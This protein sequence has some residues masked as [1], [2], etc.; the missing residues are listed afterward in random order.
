MNHSIFHL[1]LL[2][3]HTP[4]QT[5]YTIENIHDDVSIDEIFWKGEQYTKSTSAIVN[6]PHHINAFEASTY[7]DRGSYT[8]GLYIQRLVRSDIHLLA[9]D[10]TW[11][12]RFLYWVHYR[13]IKAT[14]VIKLPVVPMYDNGV[15]I[16][17]SEDHGLL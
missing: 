14:Y 12:R 4:L 3:I 9:L 6:Y 8:A 2:C 11:R 17:G 13:Q 10:L 16:I 1:T 5:F 15:L 7:V